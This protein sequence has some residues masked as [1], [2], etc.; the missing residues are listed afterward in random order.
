MQHQTYL[1]LVDLRARRESMSDREERDCMIGP[2]L[3]FEV[4][5]CFKAYHGVKGYL[6]GS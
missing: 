6:D 2:P 1:D 5:F 3:R 4:D